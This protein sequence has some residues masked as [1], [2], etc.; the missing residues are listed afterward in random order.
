MN[1][2]MSVVGLSFLFAAMISIVVGVKLAM[3]IA[4][5]AF[6]AFLL[7]LIFRSTRKYKSIIC[8]ALCVTIC[9]TYTAYKINDVEKIKSLDGQERYICATIV[10]YPTKT[11]SGYSYTVETVQIENS[12]LEKLKLI[13]Y[14]NDILEAEVGDIIQGIAELESDYA[15]Q[16]FDYAD[17]IYLSAAMFDSGSISIIHTDSSADYLFCNIRNYSK[18]VINSAMP[19]EQAS[20]VNAFLFSDKSNID[21]SLYND[22]KLCGLS[23]TTATSGMHLA[24]IAGFVMM[25]LSVFGVNKRIGAGIVIVFCML[26][27]LTVGFLP[28]IVR[29]TVMIVISQFGIIIGRKADPI[30]SL[31]I[32]AFIFVMINP[33]SAVNCA[34]LLS[35][36]ATLAMVT[37]SMQFCEFISRKIKT[38]LKIVDR[39]AVFILSSLFQTV[40]AVLFTLPV[41]LVYIKSVSVISPIAN[42]LVTPFVSVCVCAGLITVLFFG[43]GP[44][45]KIAEISASVFADIVEFLS[46]YAILADVEGIAATV[47]IIIAVACVIVF[48]ILHRY[49]GVR[50]RYAYISVFSTLVI[51]SMII[52]STLSYLTRNDTDILILP[53]GNGLACLVEDTL[54]GAG[55][56]SAEYCIKNEYTDIETIIIPSDYSIHSK[57]AKSAI[58]DY[59]IKE[60]YTAH[61]NAEEYYATAFSYGDKLTCRKAE[62]LLFVQ[63]RSSA[64]MLTAQHCKVLFVDKYIDITKLPTDTLNVD[65]LIVANEPPEHV[66]R[67]SADAVIVC[68]NDEPEHDYNSY[69]IYSTAESGDI[70]VK[71]HNEKVYIL[72]G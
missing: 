21:N 16:G 38:P 62:L 60:V 33:Y 70:T 54:I 29:A 68:T 44:A 28:S 53:S 6:I 71:I 8:V 41:I 27:M 72:G 39:V 14:T 10:D 61:Y 9:C 13:V 58:L 66:E 12:A 56:N 19:K 57:Y 46:D 32:S 63:E 36:S 50:K 1:R 23:H 37:V 24:I 22:I 15:S 65:A 52:S 43:F 48:L 31:G 35:M 34:L 30:N 49:K 26:Y 40:S 45:A 5:V 51:T 11:Q 2:A 7:L 47:S 55:G 59:N 64:I 69:N 25:I 42:L 20:V 18:G 17:G 3:M 4:A 67:I